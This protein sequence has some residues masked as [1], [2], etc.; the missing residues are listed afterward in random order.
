MNFSNKL[1]NRTEIGRILGK[2][3]HYIN[4]RMGTQANV[5][6]TEAELK[7]LRAAFDDLFCQVYRVD[8]V[9]IENDKLIGFNI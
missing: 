6:F 7:K 8:E 4:A 1:L 5:N 2:D 3:S 9:K